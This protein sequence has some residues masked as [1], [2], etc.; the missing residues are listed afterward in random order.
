MLPEYFGPKVDDQ[1]QSSVTALWLHVLDNRWKR[2]LELLVDHHLA[3]SCQTRSIPENLL[4]LDLEKCGRE[5]VDLK[6]PKD[7]QVED[8]AEPEDCL[9]SSRRLRF[10]S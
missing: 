2:R 5:V 9:R 7:G 3:E 10:E 1:F 4:S 8:T 6:L